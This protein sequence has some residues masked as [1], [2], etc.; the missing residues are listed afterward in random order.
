MSLPPFA[1]HPPLSKR[2][3]LRYALQQL[4]VGH[5]QAEYHGF[6]AY[7]HEPAAASGEAWGCL[8][9]DA[10][11]DAG[12]RCGLRLF[13]DKRDM[14]VEKWNSQIDCVI[15]GCKVRYTLGMRK[16]PSRRRCASRSV[17]AA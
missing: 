11:R 7:R 3:H 2:A 4:G 12:E 17:T 6:F 15:Q 1:C 9:A 16:E 13:F 8:G 14:N 5:A 10:I